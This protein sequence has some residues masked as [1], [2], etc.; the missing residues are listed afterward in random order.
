MQLPLEKLKEVE[1][2]EVRTAIDKGYNDFVDRIIIHYGEY[3]REYK[4]F[5]FFTVW[6]KTVEDRTETFEFDRI[7]RTNDDGKSF[8]TTSEPFD[9]LYEQLERYFSTRRAQYLL[10]QLKYHEAEYAKEVY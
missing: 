4:L 8:Y 5:G 7:H 10:D 1:Y 3:E 6:T 2:Y 9:K